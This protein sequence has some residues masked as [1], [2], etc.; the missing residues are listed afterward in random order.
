MSLDD[1]TG[2]AGKGWQALAEGRRLILRLPGGGGY[3]D[4]RRRSSEA[5]QR[6]LEGGYVSAA[7]ARQHY[8]VKT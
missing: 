5:L 3:G 8:G 4:P 7:H 2:L 1:G 6:D